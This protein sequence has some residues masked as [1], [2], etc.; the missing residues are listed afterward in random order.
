MAGPLI[1]IDAMN[2]ALRN[3][4]AV[5]TMDANGGRCG[6]WFGT[7]RSVRSIVRDHRPSNVLVVWDGE[8]GSQAR[9]SILGEYKAN[10]K[11]RIN[12]TD[13][14]GETV[15]EDRE[16]LLRQL[17]LTAE[18]L[19]MLG[20][21][22]VRC[23]GVEADDLIAWAARH[24][25]HPDVIIVSTDQ[26]LLQLIAQPQWPV[27]C[28]AEDGTEFEQHSPSDVD[29][30]GCC[31]CH[32]RME[33]PRVRV[34][35]PVKKIMFDR[36]RFIQTYGVLPENYRLMKALTGDGGDNIKGIGGFGPKTVAKTFPAM[37][38]HPCDAELIHTLAAEMGKPTAATK[39]LIGNWDVFQRN[40]SLVDLTD[41][42]MSATAA[43]QVREA[44]EKEL[45][46]REIE[47][48]MRLV[49]DG[50]T[51]SDQAF[52]STF[53]ELAARRRRL[54]GGDDASTEAVG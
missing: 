24:M 18:Y 48:R 2:L 26:D 3:Y 16:N 28:S 19:G 12:R 45:P 36:G 5:P 31:R 11:V 10:R 30:A 22:Q 21:P 44:L 1:L 51:I 4:A 7:L 41:P 29:P 42:L 8:G 54:R 33:G 9:R 35:S 27:G 14:L 23:D 25:G 53:R 40:L 49:K 34:W 38:Q 39:K 46:V 17:R 13:D 15:E 52:V 37:A 50:L 47:M 6:A 20:I 43:R 32:L